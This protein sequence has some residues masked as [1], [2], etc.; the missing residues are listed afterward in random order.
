M[1]EPIKDHTE[2][3]KPDPERKFHM[4]HSMDPYSFRWVY[5]SQ[6]NCRNKESN[7]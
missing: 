7:G 5:I 3:A 6:S 2:G 1:D 4:F